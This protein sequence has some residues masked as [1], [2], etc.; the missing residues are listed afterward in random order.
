MKLYS[1]VEENIA[2][3]VLSLQGTLAAIITHM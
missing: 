2:A 1:R 3:Q